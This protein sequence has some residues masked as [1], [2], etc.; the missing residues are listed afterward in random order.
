MRSD[1]ML[2]EDKNKWCW[3]DDYGNAGEPQDTIQKTI[4]DLMEWEPD[5]KEIWLTDEVERVVRIG[6]PNY[7]VP[8][9]D[10]ERVIEDICDYDVEDEIAEWSEPYMRKLRRAK[11]EHVEELEDELTKVYRKWEKRHRYENTGYV[12]LET[13]EYKVDANGILME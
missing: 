12:V 5:L 10:A 6:H 9:I 1:K 13:K 2:V 7:Y 8:E 4:D 3:V 11:R